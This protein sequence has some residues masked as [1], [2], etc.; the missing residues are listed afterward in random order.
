M[1]SFFT[2][3]LMIIAITGPSLYSASAGDKKEP[4]KVEKKDGPYLLVVPPAGGQDV[5]L[6]DWRFT[7][8]TRTL[9]L[10]GAVKPKQKGPEYLEFREDKS[11]TYQNGI[12]TLVPLASIRK[13]EYEREKKTVAVVVAVAGDKDETLTGTTRFI[14]IN[15]LTIEAEAQLDG[16]GAATVKFQGGI[17][18]GMHSIKF[19][20]PKAAAESKGPASA[21]I[22]TDKERTRH[23]VHDL[24]PVY[25]VDGHL[26]VLPYLMFKKTVKVDMDKLASMRFVPSDDKKK[27]SNDFEVTLKDGNKHTLTL[28]TKI[29]LPES[30]EKVKTVTFEGVLG[31]VPVGYK[32]FPAHTIQELHVAGVKDADE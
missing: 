23:S 12:L 18:K 29:D 10:T 13:I 16:L 22:A 32:L 24:Q 8:G 4:D 6:A 1:R 19:P 20:A 14:G 7:Q 28:L 11:T 21:I 25:L 27:L 3:L 31:R 9:S 2:S 30:K 5:K 17:D 26:R 15:K